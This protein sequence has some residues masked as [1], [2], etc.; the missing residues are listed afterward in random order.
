MYAFESLGITWEVRRTGDVIRLENEFGVF[1]EA[2]YQGDWEQSLRWLVEAFTKT[3]FHE[4]YHPTRI[5][6]SELY[7]LQ[8]EIDDGQSQ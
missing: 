4:A 3:L 5:E 8:K 2:P 7:P 6:V 1:S